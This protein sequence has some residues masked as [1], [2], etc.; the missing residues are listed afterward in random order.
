MVRQWQTM[1][2]NAKHSET[3][4]PQVDFCKAAQAFG[5]KYTA[6]TENEEEFRKAFKKA[7]K[8]DGPSL[9]QC[10][11]DIDT[12]VLPMVPPGKPIDQIM[13]TRT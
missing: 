3:T 10:T 7:L 13:M 2:H 12:M 1:F 4:L 5:Y 6:K 8:N 9:I 11:I